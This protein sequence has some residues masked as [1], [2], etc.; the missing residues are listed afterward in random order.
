VLTNLISIC[1]EVTHLVGQG[2]PVHVGFRDFNK[3][4]DT[5]SHSIL[6]DYMSSVQ[7]VR[8]TIH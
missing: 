5:V 7:L 4:F 1:D 2:K 8:S 3:A 6:L